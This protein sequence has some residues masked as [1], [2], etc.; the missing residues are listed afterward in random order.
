M[1]AMQSHTPATVVPETIDY[2][3]RISDI[4][5]IGLVPGGLRLNLHFEGTI[6][7][8]VLAG[9][10]VHGID[11]LVIRPDGV[12]ALD[13][14]ELI[15]SPTGDVVDVRAQ[16]YGQ[17]HADAPVP[18]IEIMRSPE[19]RWPDAGAPL[20][21]SA[22]CLTAAPSLAWMNRLV[23]AFSGTANLGAREIRVT[24]R[25]MRHVE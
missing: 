2:I 13:V 1:T 8:G 6:D 22:F 18:P 12:V 4:V 9:A 5:P 23:F 21:G 24:I 16:G 25:P 7:E 19:F 15:T 14:R 11:Y 20:V 3:A 17:S 10:S